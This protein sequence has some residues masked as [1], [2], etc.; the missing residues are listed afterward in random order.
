MCHPACVA[1][2]AGNDNN[3]RQHQRH[4]VS[5]CQSSP[6]PRLTPSP[7]SVSTV[8]GSVSPGS[9]SQILARKKRR[10]VSRLWG[11][12]WFCLFGF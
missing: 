4:H 8:T 11:T 10:G 7:F 9:A 12:V 6:P 1:L 2:K 3:M 5:P